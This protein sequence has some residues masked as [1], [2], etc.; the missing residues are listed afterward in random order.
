M[1]P[2]GAL[3]EV[4]AIHLVDLLVFATLTQGLVQTELAIVTGSVFSAR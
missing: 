3:F 1:R 2:G 4:H